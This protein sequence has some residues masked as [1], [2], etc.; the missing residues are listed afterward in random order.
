VERF[1]VA[2]HGYTFQAVA[3]GEAG[4]RPVLLLHGFPQTSASWE[5]IMAGLAAAGCRC[6]AFDQRGYSPGA[7][8]PAVEDYAL[9]LLVGDALAVADALGWERFDLVGHDWGAIVAWVVAARHPGR[10]RTLCA[11]SVPHPAAFGAALAGSSDQAEKSSYI[12][13]FRQPGGVAEQLLLGE[14][15]SGT[16]LRLMFERSGLTADSPAVATF[17]TA[18]T[19]PGALTAALNWYRA[20]SADFADEPAVSVPT[21]FVWSP[22]DIAVSRAAAEGCAAWVDAPYRF[23][24][25]ADPGHWIPEKSPDEL[26]ALLVEHLS[27]AL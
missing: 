6:V 12:G 8:P 25:L 2:A 21:L 16:G 11:V 15:G 17:I 20:M 9:D 1:D 4:A 26:V 23:C 7:R 18:M 22:A 14:D 13:V 19:E 3:S 5:G 10:V 24:E 27:D